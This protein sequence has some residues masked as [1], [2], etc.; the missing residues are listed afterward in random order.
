MNRSVVSILVFALL[1]LFG[2][3][4]LIW[5]ARPTAQQ[6]AAASSPES[7]YEVAD[8]L[9]V[10]VIGKKFQWNFRYPGGDGILNTPD[11]VESSRLLHLPPGRQI[12]FH[13]LSED[14]VYILGIPTNENSSAS[15][16][17]D[18]PAKIRELAVPT[19]THYIEHRFDRPGTYDLMV[20]P[21]CGFQSIHDPL[22]GQIVVSEQHD[23]SSLY[24][25]AQQDQDPS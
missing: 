11:D 13:I 6:S 25:P 5:L 9:E 22:M 8:E 21:L 7:P 24:P 2:G 15:V 16:K 4:G 14:Y 1:V 20:D 12:R 17:N 18:G 23:Y 19:L 3:V 10:A